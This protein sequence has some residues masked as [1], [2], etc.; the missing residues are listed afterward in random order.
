[1]SFNIVS[2]YEQ[3][4]YIYFTLSRIFG[5]KREEVGVRIAQRYSAG[6]RAG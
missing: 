6:L 5:S 3:S 1:M 4:Q 2:S